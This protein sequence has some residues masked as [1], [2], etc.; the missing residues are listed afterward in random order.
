[1]T[2]SDD[3]FV[4]QKLRKQ[5]KNI[6]C[7]SFLCMIWRLNFQLSSGPKKIFFQVRVVAKPYA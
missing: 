7:V 4:R 5:D 1:M 2:N 6:I 3:E